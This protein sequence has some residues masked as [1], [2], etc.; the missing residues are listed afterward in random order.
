[1]EFHQHNLRGPFKLT[2]VC[3]SHYKRTDDTISF[4]SESVFLSEEALKRS[5]NTGCEKLWMC[6]IA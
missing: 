5:E 1:M 6:R 2:T 3:V 4:K